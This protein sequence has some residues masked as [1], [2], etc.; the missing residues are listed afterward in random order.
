M[1]EETYRAYDIGLKVVV[2]IVTAVGV[3][4]GWYQFKQQRSD[5]LYSQFKLSEENDKAEFKRRVW[6][7]QL[8]VYMRMTSVVGKIVADLQAGDQSKD[9]LMKEIS[10]FE[11]LYW[12]ENIYVQDELVEE[13]M[14]NMHKDLQNLF[15]SLKHGD[16]ISEEDKKNRA[17]SLG[18]RALLLGRKLKEASK[19]YWFDNASQ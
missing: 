5:L 16:K 1:K 14:H 10:E 8:D 2:S 6:E 15:I 18:D 12:G 4:V 11:S 3:A 13:E 19:K 9:Q 7:K 17:Y